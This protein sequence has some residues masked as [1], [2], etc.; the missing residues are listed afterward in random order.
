[1]SYIKYKE[2]AYCNFS[3]KIDIKD[4]P[5]FVFDYVEKDE[6]IWCSYTSMRKKLVLTDKKIII[7]VQTGILG[8]TKKIHFFPYVNISS[9]A[10]EYRN[11]S[12]SLL[13]SMDSGYQLTI[14]IHN[15]DAAAKTEI[16]QTYFK[17]ID[18]IDDK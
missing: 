4:L 5:A 16:R 18:Q 12:T 9:S 8:K 3:K 2:L 17:L 1:M 10:I 15:T 6:T 14:T 13:F 7:F 11:S